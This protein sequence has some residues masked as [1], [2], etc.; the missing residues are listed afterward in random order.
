MEIGTIGFIVAL[1]VTVGVL[2]YARGY[3]EGSGSNPRTV[4]GPRS[5]DSA[6]CKQACVAWDNARQMLCAAKDDE[7]AARSRADGIR[8]Q[9]VAA[10]TAAVSLGVAAAATAVAAT[11]ATA[12]VFGI[13][14]AVILWGIA[15]GLAAASAV[16]WAAAAYLGGE[17]TA[18]EANVAAKASARQDWDSAVAG[19]RAA[20]NRLCTEAEAN[21]CLSRTAPC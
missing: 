8:G 21:A 4:P 14:A 9:L 17:L 12:S 10:I 1:I 7:A 16:A 3:N 19:I 15:I 20:V 13:P 5:S 18:A 6:D 2:I 11:A